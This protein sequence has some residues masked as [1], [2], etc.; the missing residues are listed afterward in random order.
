MNRLGSA[1]LLGASLFFLNACSSVEM[2][3]PKRAA[4]LVQGT[5]KDFGRWV[6]GCNNLGLCTAIAPV[7]AYGSDK[8][9]AHLRVIFGY[10]R[11]A[12]ARFSIVRGGETVET[13]SPKAAEELTKE[14]LKGDAADATYVSELPMRYDVPRD[15]FAHVTDIQGQWRELPPQGLVSTDVIT[16][17][18]AS[19]IDNVGT[20]SAIG[21]FAIRCPKG[22]MGQSIQAWRGWGGMAL[23]RAG[24]GNEGLNG[25]SFWF[26]SGPQGD[27]P[28]LIHFEDPEG[29]V[30]PYNS[31][32]DE[33][34][35]YLQMV[36]YFGGQL[37]SRFEDCGILRI[38]AWSFE[39]L[40]LV[41]KRFMPVCDIGIGAEDWITTYRATMLNGAGARP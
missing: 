8:D 14:L 39:G 22:H 27:P 41:E 37:I 28:R 15:G 5:A 3:P 35:G 26:M 19:R 1:L 33:K 17:I 40:K 30:E 36:H 9:Q 2:P 21:Q 23:W 7:R 31:W 24:C 20:P 10:D 16:P 29:P 34:T 4:E 6:I 18:P 13:L 38:Y 25:F 11:S 32:F 12:S